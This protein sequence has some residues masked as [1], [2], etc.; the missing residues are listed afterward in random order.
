MQIASWAEVC[1]QLASFAR[2][3]LTLAVMFYLFIVVSGLVWI[4]VLLFI[5]W[6]GT[7]VE[8]GLDKLLS[9]L[10]CLPDPAP[11]P[12]QLVPPTFGEDD[13]KEEEEPKPNPRLICYSPV[14]SDDRRTVYE[15]TYGDE[16]TFWD[17]IETLPHEKPGGRQY[18]RDHSDG[19]FVWVVEH[20]PKKAGES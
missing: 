17:L 4:L 5:N 8:R 18:M 15:G 2:W 6:I 20:P 9:G 13:D 14:A 3:L 10:M 11:A 7:T 19:K 1:T 12:P 16:V